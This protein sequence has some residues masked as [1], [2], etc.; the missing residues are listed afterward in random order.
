MSTATQ[1][2]TL[3]D[4]E[5]AFDENPFDIFT[6][7]SKEVHMKS[8]KTITIAS[9]IPITDSGKNQKAS[10]ASTASKASKASKTFKRASKASKLLKFLCFFDH[11]YISMHSYFI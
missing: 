3:L 11:S 2:L 7:P 4:D 9:S 1:G 5:K 8:G 10:K 6:L